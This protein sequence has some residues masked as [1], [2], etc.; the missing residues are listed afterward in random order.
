MC[1][2]QLS[3]QC[4]YDFGLRALKYVLVS[5]GNI[6]RE[7]I[8]KAYEEAH[9]QGAEMH[10]KDIA[11]QI[12]EQQILIQS[13]CETLTPKLVSEDIT[14][15]QSLLHDVFP[16]TTYK[17]KSMDRFEFNEIANLF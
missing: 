11:E 12:S 3:S 15:L 8:Q 4:H 6:K 17:P 13:V 1:K 9:N 7:L 5:A 2:E 10:E 14:L 16:D